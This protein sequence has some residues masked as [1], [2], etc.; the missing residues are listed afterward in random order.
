MKMK[1]KKSFQKTLIVIE[2][3]P[4]PRTN[5]LVIHLFMVNFLTFSFFSA[6]LNTRFSLTPRQ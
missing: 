3:P 2:L 1:R 6:T 4:F 5:F